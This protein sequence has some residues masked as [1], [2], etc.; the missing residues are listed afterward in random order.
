MA[1]T[2]SGGI[3]KPGGRPKLAWNASRNRKLI[4][5]YLLTDI[6]PG[7]IQWVLSSDGFKPR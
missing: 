6:T 1:P 4:R 3:S 7:E 2:K 5:L